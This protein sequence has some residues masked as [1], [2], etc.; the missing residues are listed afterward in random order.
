VTAKDIPVDARLQGKP[1]TKA[2][3]NSRTDVN[4]KNKTDEAHNEKMAGSAVPIDY[5]EDIVLSAG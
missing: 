2:A 5:I 3:K 1:K 4:G